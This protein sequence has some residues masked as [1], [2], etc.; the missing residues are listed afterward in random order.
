MKQ[1]GRYFDRNLEEIAVSSAVLN[2][3]A[4]SRVM[5]LP[6]SDFYHQDLRTVVDVIRD[7]SAEG[8][9]QID[10]PLI[11]SRLE[12][13]GKLDTAGGFE[14]IAGL[15]ARGVVTY[16]IDEI[17]NDIHGLAIKR[18]FYTALTRTVESL[19][20]AAVD[21]DSTIIKLK[22]SLD[23]LQRSTGSS[24][25]HISKLAESG[26]EMFNNRQDVYK[27]HFN[28]IDTHLR[29]FFSGELIAIGAR[30]KMGKTT[31]AIQ[32]ATDMSRDGGV[33]FY[34]LEMSE[35]EILAKIYSRLSALPTDL[36]QSGSLSG[37]D[38]ARFE[39]ARNDMIAGKYNLKIVDDMFNIDTIIADIKR[40][41]YDKNMHCAVV[42]YIQ[43]CETSTRGESRYLQ[44]GEITRKLKK[45]AQELGIVIIAL[46]Q[47]S[48]AAD[49]NNP[50]LEDF[51]ES[52]NIGNDCN[53]PIFIYY[54]EQYQTYQIKID[55]NR[56]SAPTVFDVVF[57]SGCNSFREPT[58]K[59]VSFAGLEAQEEF[60]FR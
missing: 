28:K 42:D 27:T 1:Q 45:T 56:R 9:Q 2:H 13:A 29:G 21:T 53:I 35:S 39:A 40:N 43:L 26:I 59:P 58:S 18:D 37:N 47:M 24:A 38:F 52:G 44:V 25:R 41:A 14:Y 57:D 10:L 46:S 6:S 7:I 19:N 32:L 15:V 17:I 34:S 5:S 55:R 16:N 3:S 20:T 30:A 31:L 8:F 36:I 22:E 11:V 49:K 23:I 33:C 48:K 12:R 54:N 60:S 50:S 51:R 4:M